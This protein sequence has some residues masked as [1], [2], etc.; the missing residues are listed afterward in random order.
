[1]QGRTINLPYH[2]SPDVEFCGYSAPH[3]S[4]TKIL[5]RIQCHNGTA[6]DALRGGL[7]QL[8]EIC[9]VMAGKFEDA[10]QAG[11]YECDLAKEI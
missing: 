5:L 7:D 4:E 11:D 3:P 9:G 8:K 10:M 1:V 6:I 2:F